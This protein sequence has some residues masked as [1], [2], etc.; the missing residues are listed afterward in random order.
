MSDKILVDTSAWIISFKDSG[1]QKL[2]KC[3]R[4]ALDSIFHHDNHLKTI[5]YEMDVKAIDFL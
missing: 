1:N 5:S 2:K 3:L 4:E